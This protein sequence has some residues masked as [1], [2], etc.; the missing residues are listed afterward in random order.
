MIKLSVIDR[1]LNELLILK[2]QSQINLRSIDVRAMNKIRPHIY[3]GMR[4]NINISTVLREA[5]R[6][7]M[8]EQETR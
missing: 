2:V 6:E 1:R 3:R 4:E 5:I 7:T 8:D